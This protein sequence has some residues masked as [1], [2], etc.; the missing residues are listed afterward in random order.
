MIFS[1][2]FLN[3]IAFAIEILLSM[4]LFSFML[5]K[6]NHAVLR[7]ILSIAVVLL[8]AF[9]FP[10]FDFS[11]TWRYSSLM[12]TI[13]FFVC[14][15]SLIF[16]YDVPIKT[17]FFNSVT[18]YTA[19]HLSYQFYSL[20]VNLLNIEETLGF[21]SYGEAVVENAFT[22]TQVILFCLLIIVYTIVYSIL[23][24]IF[25]LKRNN[26]ESQISNFNVVLIAALIL[27]VEVVVNSTVIYGAHDENDSL[28]IHVG[29]YNIICCVML[30]LIE[31]FI[32]SNKTLEIELD[33]TN[34]LLY[35]AHEQYEQNKENMELINIK[36]HDLKQQIR[37][38]GKNAYVSKEEL[39]DIEKQINIYD[40][41]V[42]T[43]NEALD[44]ILSEKSLICHK[45]NIILKCYADC[46]KLSFISNPDIYSLFGNAVDNAIEAVSKIEDINKRTINLYVRNIAKCISISIEN[47]YVGELSIN[48]E[49][50]IVTSKS[51]KN[52]HGFGLKSIKLIVNKYHGDMKI[53]TNDN[54]FTLAILFPLSESN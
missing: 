54:I 36:C 51:N 30:L 45:N 3:K 16:V 2:L 12:F 39:N 31:Y 49:N 15:I 52:Y 23:T 50:L 18:A 38:L 46:S 35:K 20:L 5:K 8:F 28:L 14:F 1:E 48:N 53:L 27:L 42:K 21:N 6:K 32:L 37:T 4:H 41:K 47:Y 24:I 33:T 22:Y 9:L 43:G 7:Y 10:I 44:L 11:Y 17:L 19:Q 40:S 34:Q 29:V 26:S 13:I 25:I